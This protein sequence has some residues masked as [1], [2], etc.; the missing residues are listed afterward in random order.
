MLSRVNSDIPGWL[1]PRKRTLDTIRQ[2]TSTYLQRNDVQT[3]IQD[4][5]EILMIRGRD[6]VRLDH[7]R[8][9]KACFGAWYQCL[10]KG[11]PRGGRKFPQR[12]DLKRHFLEKHQDLGGEIDAHPNKGKF[13][14]D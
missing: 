6:R 13:R 5:A 9:G 14:V 8:R 12:K 3:S 4:C 10:I 11:C 7:T 2:Y 1:E